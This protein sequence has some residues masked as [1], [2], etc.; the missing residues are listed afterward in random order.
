MNMRY[1]VLLILPFLIYCPG[2]YKPSVKRIETVYLSSL[3][4]DLYRDTPFLAGIKNVQGIKVGHIVT[5]DP[6]LTVILHKLDFFSL[7]NETGIDFIIADSSLFHIDNM[8]YYL[9]PVSMGYAIKNYEGIRFAIFSKNKDSLTIDEEVHMAIVKQRSDILWIIDNDIISLPPSKIDFYIK[10]RGLSDTV[11]TKL[12]TTPDTLILRKLH[13]FR[14]RFEATLNAYI[15][16]GGQNL[17]D[18]V[19]T[20]VATGADVDVILYPAELFQ[21]TVDADSVNVRHLLELVDFNM[22]FKKSSNKTN[23]EID[24][25]VAD[26]GYLA[27]GDIKDN[28]RTLLPDE[29]GH[30]LFTMYSPVIVSNE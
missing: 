15:S 14:D 12:T 4:E 17:T 29:T 9:I 30:Y 6:M 26:H 8:R 27:W 23:S 2:K 18:Y 16:F 21:G 24:T 7:L 22:R 5:P 11:V 20:H 19:L 3:Y 25:L 10:D 28:N 13:N 1:V